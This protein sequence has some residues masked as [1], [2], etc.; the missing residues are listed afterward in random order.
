[1]INFE[2]FI[3]NLTISLFAIVTLICCNQFNGEQNTKSTQRHNF[4]QWEDSHESTFKAKSAIGC[5]VFNNN[6]FV[7]TEAQFATNNIIQIKRYIRLQFS[8]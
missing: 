4:P 1:M 6:V 2:V 5:S 7:I 8:S 3:L